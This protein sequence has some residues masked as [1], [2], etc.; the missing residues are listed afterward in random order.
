M[1]H[2][3]GREV[4]I[5]PISVRSP[6]RAQMCIFSFFIPVL[7][8]RWFESKYLKAKADLKANIRKQ[9]SDLKAKIVEFSFFLS[10]F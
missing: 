1:A 7:I 10:F 8:H 6:A 9:L 4:L 3:E 5:H 2:W